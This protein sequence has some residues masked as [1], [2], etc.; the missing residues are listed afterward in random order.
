MKVSDIV[1]EGNKV[2]ISKIEQLIEEN[3]GL[4]SA[5]CYKLNPR[6]THD[7]YP[8][9]SWYSYHSREEFDNEVKELLKDSEILKTTS[10]SKVLELTGLPNWLKRMINKRITFKI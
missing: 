10:E 4:K 6:F 2:D 3:E 5:Y 8:Y 7:G 9:G 1:K